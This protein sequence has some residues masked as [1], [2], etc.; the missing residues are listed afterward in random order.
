MFLL[1]G[2][3]YIILFFSIPTKH[4]SQRVLIEILWDR[5]CGCAGHLHTC[6]TFTPAY[7]LCGPARTKNKYDIFMNR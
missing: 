5:E 2:G 3:R 1:R 4:I 7:L 6:G